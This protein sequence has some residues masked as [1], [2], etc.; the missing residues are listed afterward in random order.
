L[1]LLDLL[2]KQQDTLIVAVTM[3]MVLAVTML[4]VLAMTM[5]KIS[6][7]CG[8]KIELTSVRD[9]RTALS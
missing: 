2:L 6:A 5:L 7:D 1:Q 3:L 4:M 8:R 9:A